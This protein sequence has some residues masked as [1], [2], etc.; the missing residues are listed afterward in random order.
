MAYR[1]H[2]H[3][4]NKGKPG[5]LETYSRTSV[6]TGEE[7]ASGA[8]VTSDSPLGTTAVRL[9]LVE[10]WNDESEVDAVV[11]VVRSLAPGVYCYYFDGSADDGSKPVFAEVSENLPFS[12]ATSFTDG[13]N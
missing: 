9:T 10:D 11:T 4:F 7:L 6:R 1:S 12:T 3:L 13:P 5:R 2:I 8:T